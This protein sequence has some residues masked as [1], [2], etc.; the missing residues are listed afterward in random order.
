MGASCMSAIGVDRVII[1]FAFSEA[2]LAARPME[3][4]YID[5]TGMPSPGAFMLYGWALTR[6]Y[7]VGVGS[8]ER[9]VPLPDLM[10]GGDE[11]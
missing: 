4:N 2:G 7:A 11:W 5:P 9:A 1:H 8:V 6:Q 3:R 10:D